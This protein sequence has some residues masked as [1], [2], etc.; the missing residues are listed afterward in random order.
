MTQPPP[1]PV[2]PADPDG[3]AHWL[4]SALR[5]AAEPGGPRLLDALL[6]AVDRQRRLLS[7]DIQRAY[8]D[9]FIDSCA[10]WA[11]PYIGALL[12]LGQ[13]AERLEV[14]HA[15]ALRRRKGTPAALEDFAFAVTGLIARVSEGWQTTLWTQRL[16][17]PPPPRTAALDLRDRASVKRLGTPFERSRRG[18]RPAGPWTPRSVTA[19]V[20][21]WSVRQLV[22]TEA[23]P[24]DQTKLKGRFALHP[25]GIAAP[26]YLRPREAR[27]A[28]EGAD[29]ANRT[30]DESD[31][32]TRA[33]YR[34]L[35]AL[36]GP[37]DITYGG[38][39]TLAATHPLA[40][41]PGA[42]PPLISLSTPAGAVLWE[43]LRFGSVPPTGAVAAPPSRFQVLVDTQRG[44]VQLGSELAGPVRATW[45][46]AVPGRVGALAALADTDPAAR[47]VVEVSKSSGPGVVGSLADAFKLAEQRS[48]GLAPE[49]SAAGV[50][51]V[52]IRLLAGDRLEAPPP[53]SFTPRLPRWRIVAPPL[54]TP[55]VVGD[56]TLDLAGACVSLEGF[57][58]KGSLTAGP[59][60]AGLFADGLTMDPGAGG[61]R[62]DPDAWE[63]DLRA[64]RCVLG[65]VRAE[66]SALP[67]ELT[68]CVVDGR[69]RRFRACGPADEGVRTDAVAQV[70]R[71][72]PVLHAD[73]VTFAGPVRADAVDARDCVFAD[74]VDAVQQQ[75]GC[76]RTSYLGPALTTPARHPATYRSVTAPAPAFV[77]DAF[78]SSGYYC[79][80]LEP[81]HP[82]LAAAGDGGEVGA[83]HRSR[84]AFRIR[85]L[86]RR[87]GEFTPLG[88]TAEVSVAPWEER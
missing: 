87:I 29:P 33:T 60:L 37:G 73:S 20:W 69:L 23:A 50:P 64:T 15:V 68:E 41:V 4:P 79:L 65:P 48:A 78:E 88:L 63:L 10:D 62:T 31:A 22:A 45:Y 34:V 42:E 9:L 19:V 30:G 35:E 61:L 83:Y 75:E 24:F 52:E 17:H 54:A 71:F 81:D 1:Q 36:A 59:R 49:E 74:G 82:L 55:V 16:G 6:A 67:V 18:V 80:E 43:Q 21:P 76:I 11:V 53:Q 2:T 57:F 32:P 58:L 40:T 39:L 14:A 44:F 7:E 28:A 3:V 70:N 51:D 46:R 85:Q 27:V 77:S 66:L 86:R 5:D 56:L 12:G 26:L 8:D 13:D 84:R 47:V 72:G 25:L 38:S